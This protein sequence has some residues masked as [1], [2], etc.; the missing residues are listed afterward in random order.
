[1]RLRITNGTLSAQGR[2]NNVD[3]S[4]AVVLGRDNTNSTSRC[5]AQIKSANR[6]QMKRA[7]ITG[8]LLV[9][10]PT[11]LRGSD[12]KDLRARYKDR[13][14]V[15]LRDGLAVGICGDSAE[16]QQLTIQLYADR[17]EFGEKGFLQ[18]LH[19]LP[20]LSDPDAP[21]EP[22]PCKGE[23]LREPIHKGEVLHVTRVPRGGLEARGRF[24]L[25]VTNVT[26]HQQERG[27]GA[28]SHE[29]YETGYA[30]IIVRTDS[31]DYDQAAAIL[32]GWFKPFDSASE[33]AQFGNTASGVLV[34]EVKAGMT[35]AE[36][37]SALGPPSTRVDLGEKVLYKYKDMTVEFHDGKVTDVR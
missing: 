27:V 11:L 4:R 32:D 6:A 22:Q 10:L 3:T 8:L 36:V 35:F 9:A 24:V 19:N 14:L 33:A 5:S 16:A 21:Y 26:P 20:D 1:M 12:G 28:Y 31:K 30:V 17:V 7:I 13:Y 15:V 18:V 2:E 34:K 37:E 25:W 29:T 23:P